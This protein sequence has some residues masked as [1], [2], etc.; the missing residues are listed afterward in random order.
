MCPHRP[1]ALCHFPLPQRSLHTG[2]QPQ[3]ATGRDTYSTASTSLPTGNI[4]STD[5]K[6]VASLQK[7]LAADSNKRVRSA[8]VPVPPTSNPSSSHV[9]VSPAASFSFKSYMADRTGLVNAALEAA[10][11]QRYPHALSDAIRYSMFTGGKR[12]KAVLCMA[13]CDLAGGKIQLPH[14]WPRQ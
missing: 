13:A 12:L 9:N 14:I 5:K 6:F 11:P 7:T 1:L 10:L 4:P 2:L 3:V 8:P